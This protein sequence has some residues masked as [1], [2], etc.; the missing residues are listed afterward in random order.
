MR[1]EHDATTLGTLVRGSDGRQNNGGRERGVTV[2]AAFHEP[3]R[4]LVL[5]VAAQGEAFED[6]ADSFPGLLFAL[7][8]GYGDGAG[9]ARAMAKVRAGAP[10]RLIAAE[11]G[12]P[13]WLRRLPPGAF[14]APLRVLPAEEFFAEHVHGL[15]PVS[16]AA[17]GG[18]LSRVLLANEVCGAEAALWIG[19]QYRGVGPAV[20]DPAL[21]HILAWIWHTAQPDAPAHTLMRRTWQP[22]ISARRAAEEVEHWRHRLALAVALGDGVR[23]TWLEEGHCRGFDFVALRTAQDFIAEAA[24]MDNC[25]DQFA[26]RLEGRAVRVFSVRKGGR[27]VANLEIAC[28]EQELGMPSIAQLRAAR[29]RRAGS[30]VWQ[31][32][33]AWLGSQSLRAA[34]PALLRQ[35][36]TLRRRAIA[37]L[38]RPFLDTMKE[39]TRAPFTAAFGLTVRKLRKPTL[40]G[41]VP[42]PV[43][44][45]RRR[46]SPSQPI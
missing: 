6:L 24:S 33:Y 28:H 22:Q 2:A 13:M 9:L 18:W 38:W 21:L 20:T 4:R 36:R 26:H 40:A 16:T 43:E 7:A 11:L 32:T 10:L 14:L 15:I 45:T 30:D 23:D 34:D 46:R 1:H 44:T 42:V 31:A 5:E 35:H 27:S 3:F 19:R 12:L 29:N 37:K 41:E 8:T 39:E 25:L 17:T